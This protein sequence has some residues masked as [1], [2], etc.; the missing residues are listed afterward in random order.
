MK[1]A[2]LTSAM[3]AR[4]PVHTTTEHPDSHYG[5]AVWVDDEGNAYMQEGLE[6]LN[7]LYKITDI[8]ETEDVL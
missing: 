4:V 8:E 1:T 5:K 3:G 7:P 2:I 6:P